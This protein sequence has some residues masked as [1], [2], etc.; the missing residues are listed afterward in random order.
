M[1]FLHASFRVNSQSLLQGFRF[2][3]GPFGCPFD[4]VSVYHTFPFAV[5]IRSKL[6]VSPVGTGRRNVWCATQHPSNRRQP[7]SYDRSLGSTVG[8]CPFL[9]LCGNF[10]R[11]F[12]FEVVIH[13]AVSFSNVTLQSYDALRRV[14]KLCAFGEMTGRSFGL[15]FGHFFPL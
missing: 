6:L 3:L 9:F 12:L 14:V 11:S 7:S 2:P 10:S 4:L 13:S 8:G 1:T 15:K 5:G